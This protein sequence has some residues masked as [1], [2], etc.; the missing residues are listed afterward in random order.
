MFRCHAT[1]GKRFLATRAG[2]SDIFS[3]KSDESEDENVKVSEPISSAYI[4]LPFCKKKCLYCDFPVVALGGQGKTPE[5]YKNDT[6]MEAYIDAVCTE[7]E[8]TPIGHL[9]RGKDEMPEENTGSLDTVYFGGGTPSL[10]S[11]KSLERILALLERK[12]GINPDA[13]ITIEADPGTFDDASLKSYMNLGIRRVS[14]GVQAFDEEL[15]R[16]CGRSHSL[17]DVY[18]AIEDVHAANI[19]SWSLD[20]I[21]G[22]PHLTMERWEKSI[23][24]AIDADPKHLSSYDLQ[25]EPGT[26]FGKMYR[27]GVSPLPTDKEAADMYSRASYLF[28]N[29]GYEHY[30]LSSY[31][32]PGHQCKHNGVYWNGQGYYAFG[33]GAASYID[34]RRVTRPDKIYSYLKWVQS[35]EEQ[36]ESELW[37]LPHVNGPQATQED[38]LTDTIMLQLRKA[39]GLDLGN[40]IKTYKYGRIIVDTILN[41]AKDNMERGLM[42]YDKHSAHIRLVDPTGFLLSND[43]ISDIFVAL[44]DIKSDI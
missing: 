32:R 8:L 35:F 39:S 1:C 12:Y 43:V 6:L 25:V 24:C 29:A 31:A 36:V 11:M 3:L 14:V 34:K 23:M 18:K 41:A 19:P 10:I 4:H 2:S 20:L 26:P 40:I 13:E 30:E 15:L 44:D 22:L 9:N 28:Q 16:I 27:A 33:M 38:I 21:S 5:Q 17:Y 7:I 37:P 42:V